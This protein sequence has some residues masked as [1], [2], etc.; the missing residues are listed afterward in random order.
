MVFK[1]EKKKKKKART[2]TV[3]TSG[4]LA[5]SSVV[6]EFIDDSLSPNSVWCL[7]SIIIKAKRERTT[8]KRKR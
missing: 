7:V 5:H 1:R 6:L 4:E 3:R 2:R 8:R